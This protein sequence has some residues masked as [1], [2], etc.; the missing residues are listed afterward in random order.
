MIRRLLSR[1]A[2]RATMDLK[3]LFVYTYKCI[4]KKCN[5]CFLLSLTLSP[6]MAHMGDHMFYLT[7]LDFR[8]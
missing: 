6:L 8:P 2:R 3:K 7:D 4:H 1:P 5:H